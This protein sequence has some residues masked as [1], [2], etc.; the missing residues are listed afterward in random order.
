MK[1]VEA[2]WRLKI[3]EK[4]PEEA[5]ECVEL[6]KMKEISGCRRGWLAANDA[7]EFVE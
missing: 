2:S 4:L 7:N 3:K 1:G 5:P 6:Q